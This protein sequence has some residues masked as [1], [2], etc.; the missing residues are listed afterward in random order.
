LN[1]LLNLDVNDWIIVKDKDLTLVIPGDSLIVAR[2]T[3]L[4]SFFF[5][6]SLTFQAFSRN[7]SLVEMDRTPSAC[8]ATVNSG[9]PF[10]Q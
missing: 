7:P 9:T 2:L 5:N 3:R 1:C 10:D 8:L 6:F 4:L